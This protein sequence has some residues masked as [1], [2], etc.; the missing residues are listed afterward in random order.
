VFVNQDY[1]KALAY[2]GDVEQV[3]SAG[4]DTSIFLWDVVTLV[5]LTT[6][7]NTVTSKYL[8]FTSKSWVFTSKS[9]VFTSKLWVFTSK[10]WK[11]GIISSHFFNHH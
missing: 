5:A 4:F 2:A 11:F 10:L 6:S 8:I 9:W 3:A 1:V 7:N